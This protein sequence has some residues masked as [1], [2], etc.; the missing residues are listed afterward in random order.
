MTFGLWDNLI[1]LY[2]NLRSKTKNFKWWIQYGKQNFE[3]I[4]YRNNKLIIIK[5]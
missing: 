2:S 3:K 1:M 4:I 5:L